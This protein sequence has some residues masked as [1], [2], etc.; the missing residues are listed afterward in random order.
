MNKTS[1]RYILGNCIPPCIVITSAIMLI[2]FIVYSIKFIELIFNHNAPIRYLLRLSIYTIPYILFV[3]LPISTICT[4]LYAAKRMCSNNELMAL[5]CLGKSKMEIAMAFLLF[6]LIVCGIHYLISFYVMPFSYRNLRALEKEV[7]NQYVGIFIEEG[8]FSDKIEGFTLYVE[9]K[10]EKSKFLHLFVRDARD[11]NKVVTI[12]AEFGEIKLK[13][14]GKTLELLMH[15][16][17]YHDENTETK[18]YSMLLF[19]HYNMEIDLDT[20]SKIQGKKFLEANER[21]IN[22]MFSDIDDDMTAKMHRKIITYGNQRII[23][24]LTNIAI[25]LVMV[26]IILGEQYHRGGKNT[27][28]LAFLSGM[29]ILLFNVVLQNIA[30]RDTD[31]IAAMY[32]ETVTPIIASVVILKLQRAQPA[33]TPQRNTQHT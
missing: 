23:W 27:F 10:V 31:F 8:S 28:L 32:A 7:E 19:N 4:I 20:F 3:I 21:Y 9:K 25:T 24:P 16:G 26:S 29:T 15:N 13:N 18:K 22:E 30:L 12:I 14:G 1:T 5:Q 2:I 6:T 11:K 17:S 33:R